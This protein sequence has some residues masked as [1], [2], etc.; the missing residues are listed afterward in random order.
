MP[1]FLLV[2]F[3][4]CTPKVSTALVTLDDLVNHP[5]TEALTRDDLRSCF[6]SS[7][8]VMDTLHKEHSPTRYLRINFHFMNSADSTHNFSED[9]GRIFVH[10]LIHVMQLLFDS[11]NKLWLPQGNDI[12]VIPVNIKYVL[13]GDNPK[14]DPQTAGI[15]FHYDDDLYFYLHQG[16]RSNNAD[17]T[18]IE[19]YGKGL[20]SIINIFI[21]PHHPD[22]A[23]SPT[24]QSGCVGIALGNAVKI[25]GIFEKGLNEWNVRGTFNHEIGHVLG[26]YHAWTFDG[27]ED[28]PMHNNK[29]WVPE[30]PGCMGITSNNM[31]DYNAFQSALSPCQVGLLHKNLS[32]TE[33]PVR[34][35]LI[36]TWCRYD[37][38]KKI[39]IKD[40]ITWYGA[41]DLEGDVEILNGASLRIK[42]RVSMPQ[43]SVIRVHPGGTLILDD[44]RLHNDC[45]QLWRGIEI[46][47]IKKTEGKV[48]KVGV[49]ILENLVT[50]VP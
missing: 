26:L 14:E 9:S 35:L 38:F 22:S 6:E 8:Y 40:T 4:S 12:P 39:T 7:A 33:N 50:I 32:N 21:L 15:Y 19:K 23:R 3:E 34:T 43:G 18:V 41:R 37:P 27:C 25:S 10:K 42:C 17:Y 30:N 48:I 1:I 36:K 28:T 11:N 47:K 44:C 46:L 20:D 29:C 16:S 13:T 45:G 24:Y 49:P 31:M 5:K 2:I